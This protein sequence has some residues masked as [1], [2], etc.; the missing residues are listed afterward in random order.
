MS[1]SHEEVVVSHETVGD[2]MRS[3]M[4]RETYAD[5]AVRGTP[6]IRTLGQSMYWAVPLS[7][8]ISLQTP[9]T[10]MFATIV[11][12]GQFPGVEK[13]TSVAVK[14]SCRVVMSC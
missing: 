5:L 3:D 14:G 2:H 10:D 11:E 6:T 12:A 7:S 9:W 8:S 1:L 13:L 4:I